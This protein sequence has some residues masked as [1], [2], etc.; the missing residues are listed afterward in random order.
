MSKNLDISLMTRR[1]VTQIQKEI[2]GSVFGQDC[3]QAAAPRGIPVSQVVQSPYQQRT[4]RED[5]V[6]DL[7][8]SIEAAGLSNPIIVR[9]L[10]ESDT[11]ELIAGHHRVA[12]FRR[13]GHD[14]IPA[15]VRVMP[16][17]E[18]A[19][20]LTLDNTLHAGLTDWELFKHMQML[21][22][23]QYVKNKTDLAALMGRS[24]AAVYNLEAFAVIPASVTHLLDEAP[25]LVGGTLAY[26]L[27]LLS[28]DHP[29]IVAEAIT[30]LADKK[31]KQAAVVA[32]VRNKANPPVAVVPPARHEFK[33]SGVSIVRQAGTATISGNIDLEKLQA[34]IELN[35]ATLCKDKLA[36]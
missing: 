2:A 20:A 35:I 11:Y 6:D 25:D 9:Y 34:L 10:S 30:L 4:L 32:W 18:A 36:A 29:A 28:V 3:A 26:E 15:L 1:P 14:I 19:R 23:G 16:D 12:A 22:T 33:L 31:M 27:R 7:V 24:R 13:L 8:A 17:A 5:H 21:T